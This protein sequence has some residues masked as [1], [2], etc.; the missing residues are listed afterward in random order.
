MK[1][2]Y[3]LLSSRHKFLPNSIYW[4]KMRMIISWKKLG[5][6]IF[7]L[8]D[9]A[10][11]FH[12]ALQESAEIPSSSWIK[13]LSTVPIVSK[14]FVLLPTKSGD[15]TICVVGFIVEDVTGYN[16]IGRGVRGFVGRIGGRGECPPLSVPE[17]VS[18]PMLLQH[19]FA[20]IY[21]FETIN[22]I[23]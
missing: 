16:G 3:I 7:F 14:P 1:I 13:L 21:L 18:P 4:Q 22:E 12:N 11:I 15:G 17:N 5:N 20:S 23:F 8:L 19:S 9:S 10:V 6:K 2:F